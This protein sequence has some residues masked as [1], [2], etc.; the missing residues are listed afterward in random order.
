MSRSSSFPDPF[1][2]FRHSPFCPIPAY[3]CSQRGVFV[4]VSGV[5]KADYCAHPMHRD[6]FIPMTGFPSLTPVEIKGYKNVMNLP[7]WRQNHDTFVKS[8][9]RYQTG[10]YISFLFCTVVSVHKNGT[11]AIWRGAVRSVP[12]PSGTA[13]I[14]FREPD[15]APYG[16]TGGPWAFLWL[17]TRHEYRAAGRPAG[18]GHTSWYPLPS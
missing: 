5:K 6:F 9:K 16:F 15:P 18:A 10:K 3:Y 14:F 2:K 7:D 13:G 12:G 11:D 17:C 1:F 4:P 8:Q